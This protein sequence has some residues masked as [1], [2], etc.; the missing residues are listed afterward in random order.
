M[1]DFDKLTGL[2]ARYKKTII[3]AGQTTSVKLL[4]NHNEELTNI[5]TE[6]LE[7]YLLKG[8]NKNGK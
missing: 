5:E 7:M 3:E 6:I 8:V 2:L 1:N 4:D